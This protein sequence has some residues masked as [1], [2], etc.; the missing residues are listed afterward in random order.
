M[1][2]VVL[3]AADHAGF[4]VKEKLK[5]FLL[6]RGYSIVDLSPKL[7]KGDDYP[8]YAFELGKEVVKS[9]N[10]G[11]LVCGTGAGMIIAANKVKGVRAA[12]AYDAFT[13]KLSREH[14]DAN[15]VS[16][17]GWHIPFD[18][19]KKIA[20]TFLET[21]FSGDKRHIRRIKKIEKYEK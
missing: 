1:K 8:D 14:N 21:K 17:S 12:D 9:G 13:A 16:L 20:I 18:R 7:I 5:K 10:L 2:R 19:I 11:I 3:I 15:V 6:E 4:A